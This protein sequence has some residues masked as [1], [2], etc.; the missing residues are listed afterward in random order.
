MSKSTQ[1]KVGAIALIGAAIENLKKEARD[2]VSI[3]RNSQFAPAF[4]AIKSGEA[5]VRVIPAISLDEA[6]TQLDRLPRETFLYAAAYD[7]T[8]PTFPTPSGEAFGAPIQRDA[9]VVSGAAASHVMS[10]ARPL[11]EDLTWG[12]L[13][14]R[15]LQDAQRVR[16]E[17]GEGD[18]AIF[19]MSP[20]FGPFVVPFPGHK[21]ALRYLRGIDARHISYAA[22]VDVSDPQNPQLLTEQLYAP[23]GVPIRANGFGGARLA[24]AQ[25]GPVGIGAELNLGE[26]PIF[27]IFA[28]I[29]A[30]GIGAGLLYWTGVKTLLAFIG[31]SVIGY[32]LRSQSFGQTRHWGLRD[33]WDAPGSA[34]A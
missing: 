2:A 34:R 3:A 7:A 13:R 8:D 17:H 27:N 25:V 19:V 12:D 22:A 15:A 11:A 18:A 28:F 14:S 20:Q 1:S 5:Q 30:L 31:G 32:G 6:I 16:L 10:F 33:N 23:G 21:A 24:P 4:L 29:A 26:T 9:R